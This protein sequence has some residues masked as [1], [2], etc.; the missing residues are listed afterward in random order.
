[1]GEVG[2]GRRFL[3][4]GPGTGVVTELLVEKLGK[5]DT[6]DIVEI[7]D[8]FYELIR[9]KFRGDSRV[10]VYHQDIVKFSPHDSE[11]KPL[12]YDA[13]VTG[14]PLNGLPTVDLLAAILG[15]YERLAKVGAP[16]SEV[17][18]VGTATI[19]N[20]F[21]G[22]EFKKVSKTKDAFFEYH[23]SW[24]EIEFWNI[25]V[26]ARINYLTVQAISFFKK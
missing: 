19:G 23:K 7:E 11:G 1:M 4:V 26:P 17:E 3:E 15:A 10:H 18:Y 16:I 20:L 14:V 5:N 2:V 21:R 13:I 22:Q 9:E 12:K 8:G 25:P 24:S 6:L